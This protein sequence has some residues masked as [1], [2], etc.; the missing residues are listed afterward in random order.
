MGW[1]G[2]VIVMR[3]SCFLEPKCPS[4]E[5]CP[6]PAGPRH[7]LARSTPTSGGLGVSLSWDSSAGDSSPLSECSCHSQL[8]SLSSRDLG[9]PDK[10]SLL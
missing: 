3:P 6:L 5:R 8:G 7:P 1:R 2:R 9:A 10:P 4:L